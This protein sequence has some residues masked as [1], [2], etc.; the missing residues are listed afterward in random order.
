MAGHHSDED[1]LRILEE[2]MRSIF[3]AYA[4]ENSTHIDHERIM[5]LAADCGVLDA[6]LSVKQLQHIFFA[7]G[8][9]SSNGKGIVLDYKSFVGLLRYDHFCT[10]H[11]A[12]SFHRPFFGSKAHRLHLAVFSAHISLLSL[13]YSSLW[14]FFFKATYITQIGANLRNA[15]YHEPDVGP[16][17]TKFDCWFVQASRRDQAW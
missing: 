6:D 1:D 5:E 7:C 16:E 11:P 17:E 10:T 2:S 3:K 12:T 9:P 4:V 8:V 13:A 15:L 14:M